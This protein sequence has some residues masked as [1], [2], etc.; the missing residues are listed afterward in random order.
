[1]PVRANKDDQPAY[2]TDDVIKDRV[3][4]LN[5]AQQ[6]MLGVVEQWLHAQLSGGQRNRHGLSEIEQ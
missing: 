4:N 5:L 1:M 2:A 6:C 3:F